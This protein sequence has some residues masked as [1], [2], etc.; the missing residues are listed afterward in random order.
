MHPKMLLIH[1]LTSKIAVDISDTS[2]KEQLSITSITI[3]SVKTLYIL[4][5]DGGI[6]G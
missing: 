3:A 1:V 6:S 4:E 2:N 5:C